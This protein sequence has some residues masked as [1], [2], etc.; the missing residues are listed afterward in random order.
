[1]R[2]RKRV[3]LSYTPR[4]CD[5]F[6][7][8]LHEQSLKGWHF[9]EWRFGLVFEKGEPKDIIYDI[10][11]SP[12][13][14]DQDMRPS[15][16]TMDFADYCEA[17]GWKL[18]DSHG[19]ICV[20]KKLLEDAR[21]IVSKE[22][23]FEN[24]AKEEKADWLRT[25]LLVIGL[26]VFYFFEFYVLAF[27][28]WAFDNVL[29]ILMFT[30]I[31]MGIAGLIER[32]YL[33]IW[34]RQQR[35]RLECGQDLSYR[36][37]GILVVSRRRVLLVI[38]LGFF[39]ISVLVKNEIQQ[40]VILIILF[41]GMGMIAFIISWWKPLG[42]QKQ[43]FEVCGMF[44]VTTAILVGIYS[45]VFFKQEEP[46]IELHQSILGSY[47]FGN[48]TYSGDDYTFTDIQYKIYTSPYSWVIEKLWKDENREMEKYESAVMEQD[49]LVNQAW[50]APNGYAWGMD[51][52][53]MYYMKYPNCIVDIYVRENGREI[54]DGIDVLKEFLQEKYPEIKSMF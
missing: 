15:E 54:Y 18:L 49:E 23:R 51:G 42:E 39:V 50:G 11:I 43:I 24:I 26:S 2:T 9:K 6:A 1:M 36:G 52:D 38:I 25:Y 40:L 37:H 12:K 27:D 13:A 31:I 53:Y 19:K 14:S 3:F 20:F 5:A 16:D 35:E 28:R 46:E 10:E 8:Y 4:E 45:D 22:E 47:A 30:M 44:L 21:P 34:I 32:I 41:A 33:N 29:L 17:A 7:D 48:G